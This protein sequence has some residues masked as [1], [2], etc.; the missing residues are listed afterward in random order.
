MEVRL[1][2]ETESRLNELSSKSGRP[3]DALVEEALAGYLAEVSQVRNLLD[4]RYDDLKAGRIKPLD[5]D[6]AFER[7]RR[8]T[9]DSGRR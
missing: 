5:G 2:P 7:L 3:I 9:K 8:S 4:S 6:E 1:K